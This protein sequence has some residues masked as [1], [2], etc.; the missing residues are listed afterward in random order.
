MDPNIIFTIKNYKNQQFDINIK[1][2]VIK[3]NERGDYFDKSRG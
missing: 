3:W 1:K 2:I